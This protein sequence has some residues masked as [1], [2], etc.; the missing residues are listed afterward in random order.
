MSHALSPVIRT[1]IDQSARVL[2]TYR[3]DPGLIPEHA[4]GERRIT[5]GG[6]GDRQLFELVQNAADEIA[7]MP[8]GRVHVVL[9][10]THLYCANEGTPVTPAGA[11][12]ILRMSMSNKRGGQIGRFGVGVKSV[13]VVSDTPEF[14]SRTGCFGFDRDWAY[15]QIKGI[16]GVERLGEKFEAPVLRMA[17]HLDEATER[18]KDKVLDELMGSPDT[19][20]VVRLPLLDGAAERLGQDMHALPVQQRGEDSYKPSAREGFPTGFQL[21]SPHVGSVTLEDRR[22]HPLIRRVLTT[23]QEGNVH[24]VHEERS[25]RQLSTSRW[26]VFTHTHQL[27][28][29]ARRSAGEMHSRVALDVS[30]AVPGY[31][32]D[33][34]SGLLTTP[35]GRGKFWSFFPTKYDM[36]LSGAL[37]GAWKTNEDR[38]N[39]LDSSPFN[40]ELIQVGARLVVDSLRHLVPAEDPAAYLPLLPGRPRESETVSWADRYLTGQIWSMAAQ[41]PSLPDQN[42]DLC[43]PRDVNT[44]PD[45][46]KGDASALRWLK[47]WNGC[48]GRPANW[49]HPSV[50]ANT[51]RAG[52]VEHI[53]KVANRQRATVREWL[54]ALVANGTSE[55]SAAAIRIL[56]DMIR[57]ASPFAEEARKA[58]IVL[59]E[60]HGLVPPVAG[61]V[62]RHATLDGLKDDLVYVDMRLSD[63]LSL[64]TDLATVGIRE[65]DAR[66]RFIG[67]LD[68]GFAGY[69]PQDWTRFWELFHSAG[70]SHISGEVHSRLPTPLDTLNVRTADGRYRPM[71]DCMLPGPVLNGTSDPSIAVDMGFHSD[72]LSF[73]REVGLRD[74]PSGGYRPEGETWFDEYKE[75]LYQSYC[76][77]LDDRASRPLISR[78]KLEGA[79][80]GGPLHLL[81]RM[82]DQARADFVKVLSDDSVVDQ[83]TRQIGAQVATRQATASPIRWMLRRHGMVSTSQGLKR[84]GNAVGPQLD[85]YRD[86]LPVAAI[87]AEKA[88]KLGLPTTLDSVPDEHWSQLLTELLRS[89]DDAFVGNTYVMLTRLEVNFP[90]DSLTRCRVGKEWDTR[91]DSEIAVAAGPEEYRALRAEQLPALLTAGPEDAALMVK[92]W[93]ML[94]FSDVVTKETRHV[95][96]GEPVPLRDEFPTLRLRLGNRINNYSLLQCSELEE[97]LRTPNG[98]RPTPLRSALLGTTVLVLTPEDRLSA[99]M[100]ADLELRWG[101]G[102]SGC[103]A[104]LAAQERQEQDQ[105]VQTAL[106]A[107]RESPAVVD[108]LR[109]LLGA[110]TLRRG[111]PAGLLESERADLDGADPSPQRIAQMAFNAHGDGVLQIHVKDLAAA[112]PSIAPSSFTGAG[113]AIKFISDLGF[114]DSFAGSRA[115]ALNP[116]IDVPGPSEFPRLHDYQER[117][118]TNVFSMLDRLSPQRGMLSL[119]TG[120]GKTRVTA[121]AVIRWV[122]QNEKLDGPILWI[123]QTEELCEQAVQSWQF[124]WS[125][126][127]A[128]TELA[129]SRFWSTNEAGPVEGRPH[130]IVAT[131]AKLRINLGTEAYAWLRDA[132]LV[133]VDEAH[134]AIAPQYTEILDHLGLNQYRT[135]RHLL[136]LTATPFRNTNVDETQRLIRRFG[137]RRLDEGI[138]L[139]GDPYDELQ[140]LGMLARVE[141]RELAGGTIELTRDEKERTDQLSILSKAAEQRLADD[142][143][144]NRRIIDEIRRM[145]ADWPVLVFATSVSHA[146]FLAAKLNDQHISAAAVDSATSSTDRRN[147]IAAFRSGRT[148][149]LTNYG[150]LSQGF[151]APAT[152][153]V[154]VARPTY[155]PNIYQQMIGRG[156]RGPRNGGKETCLIL[157]V[158][159]NITNYGKALAFT[160]FEHLWSDK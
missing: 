64:S 133:I 58:R 123:A 7:N 52:K 96:S 90:E 33:E 85:A 69:S 110:D 20:T 146:K 6:Y 29:T 27:T 8:G 108:K 143:D 93:G 42:G 35:K 46:G 32:H 9:T 99:L 126:V 157:N 97:V 23:E 120:A 154:V 95:A 148:R 71:R 130:L 104:V 81:P 127:G 160:Q 54:E 10:E 132:A 24:T 115:P 36:T 128:E 49:L 145:P 105:K 3:V 31:G 114:P 158:R 53:L 55:A 13:L 44:H 73:F 70:S 18:R 100:A 149:V 4:N 112:Y 2:E 75:A 137:G 12:T 88:R 41:L 103:E 63:D 39:L 101:L 14:F 56:A 67:V 82:S 16:P 94:P 106:R 17:R 151:D 142:H 74:R 116:K 135:D 77:K 5:Q 72:D 150:V 51:L 30:W 57:V 79:A 131:D 28:E 45:M 122:K 125:K 159:D 134:M 98:I 50:E 19:A 26:K 91:E 43:V 38:Q 138:F 80:V 59:T 37:N 48:P 121:E 1:V 87:S 155:S 92:Q 136:G 83:W 140:K 153:A 84:L 66:G 124:V 109:L 60:E 61:K 68:Q 40:E 141:H 147:R 47:T 76:R 62:F 65:A 118:A 129:I 117:L 86:V 22:H 78:M 139:S 107:V 25:K 102:R 89:E 11:E 144:R 113:S 21:F 152:R 156:L 119:P 15:E 111:L 34:K